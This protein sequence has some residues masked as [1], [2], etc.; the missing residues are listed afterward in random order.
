MEELDLA[1]NRIA[2]INKENLEKNKD[3]MGEVRVMNLAF[4]LIKD[5]Y[6]MNI[7]LL[8]KLQVLNLG[9]IYEKYRE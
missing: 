2:Q 9:T 1:K 4:N 6:D 8:P 3:G 7:G 5:I